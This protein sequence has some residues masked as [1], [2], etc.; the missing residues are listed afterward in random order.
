[1]RSRAKPPKLTRPPRRS[2]APRVSAAQRMRLWDDSGAA[3]EFPR[4]C[5]NL[6]LLAGFDEIGHFDLEPGFEPRGFVGAAAG[7]IAADARLGV[8]DGQL[9]LRRQLQA[10]R[11]AVELIEL[12]H[13]SF[14]EEVERVSQ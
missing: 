13:G 7:G 6:D 11:V 14:D 3:C 8:L 2:R 5:V 10:D 9:D 4:L 1:M 12:N